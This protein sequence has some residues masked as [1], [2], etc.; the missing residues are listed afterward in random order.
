MPDTGRTGWHTWLKLK[1]AWT[2]PQADTDMSFGP[3]KFV[4]RSWKRNATKDIGGDVGSVIWSN[5]RDK[6]RKPFL[7]NV[8]I[9]RNSR[10]G[11]RRWIGIRLW[12]IHGTNF[13]LSPIR[14]RL[15][16]EPTSFADILKV[17]TKEHRDVNGCDSAQNGVLGSTNCEWWAMKYQSWTRN[18]LF[19]QKLAVKADWIMGVRRSGEIEVGDFS[20]FNAFKLCRF[21]WKQTIQM[22]AFSRHQIPNKH[23]QRS[24]VVYRDHLSMRMR[25]ISCCSIAKRIHFIADEGIKLI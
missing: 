14:M 16:E 6:G 3:K 2:L 17:I 15:K 9:G 10:M 1:E 25:Q 12:G 19:P 13:L 20:G 8:L 21:N 11:K 23:G 22:P 5:C 18:G 24:R 7:T 4:I